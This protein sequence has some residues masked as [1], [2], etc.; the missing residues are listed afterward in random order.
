MPSPDQ[1]EFLFVTA[2][3]HRID[4]VRQIVGA[5]D[6]SPTAADLE[7]GAQLE[8]IVFA[9]LAAAVEAGLPKSQPAVWAEPELGEAVLPRGRGMAT[10]TNASV[11]R[12]N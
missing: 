8:G 2:I 7:R 6:G 9:G 12:P 3:D 11:A 10:P 1:S 5:T 4:F